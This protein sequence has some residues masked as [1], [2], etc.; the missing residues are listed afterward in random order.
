MP[1]LLIHCHE[2]GVEHLRQVGAHGLLCD[3][4]DR[5]QFGGREC[6]VGHQRGEGVRPCGVAE[7]RGDSG[8]VGA[9]FHGSTLIEPSAECKRLS[10]LPRGAA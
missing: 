10:S 1:A 4:A 7:Q 3:A 8:D 9:V 6:P 2:A 5:R